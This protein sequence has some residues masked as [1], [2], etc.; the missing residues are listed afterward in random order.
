MVQITH[1]NV[2]TMRIARCRAFAGQ[3]SVILAADRSAPVAADRGGEMVGSTQVTHQAVRRTAA[4][5]PLPG[6]VH[7]TV[8]GGGCHST[9]T[10]DERN[11]H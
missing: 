10:R 2:G 1:R 11:G 5:Q 8:E 9:L 3:V 4:S 7:G 6:S